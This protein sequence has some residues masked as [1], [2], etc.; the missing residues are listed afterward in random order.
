MRFTTLQQGVWKLTLSRVI[1]LDVTFNVNAK[2]DI[3]QSYIY[4]LK[5]LAH[6]HVK[7]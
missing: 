7:Y 5:D 4:R 6:T 3:Q 2:S 1:L